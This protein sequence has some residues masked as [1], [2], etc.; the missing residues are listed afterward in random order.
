MFL[1][2]PHV[3]ILCIPKFHASAAV[4]AIQALIPY[5]R[6]T[7]SVRKTSSP[8]LIP[9]PTPLT[10]PN[11]N[12]LR[13]FT[14]YRRIPSFRALQRDHPLPIFDLPVFLGLKTYPISPTE[15]G[16]PLTRYSNIGFVV[17]L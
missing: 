4:T 14:P 2:F 11:L 6:P 15:E 9:K 8:R 12:P 5:H 10:T 3:H 1:H 7:T 17:G 13:Y 16:A